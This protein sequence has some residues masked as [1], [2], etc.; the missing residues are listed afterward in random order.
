VSII[1]LEDTCW[2]KLYPKGDAIAPGVVA[3]CKNARYKI[4]ESEM[5]CLVELQSWLRLER[6]SNLV[7]RN[8][9]WE[10]YPHLSFVPLFRCLAMGFGATRKV[11]RHQKHHIPHPRVGGVPLPLEFGLYRRLEI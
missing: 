5:D 3:V 1:G 11:F 2:K 9:T 8:S 6:T 7:K 4:V 10:D